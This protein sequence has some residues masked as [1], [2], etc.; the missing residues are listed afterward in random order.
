MDSCVLKTLNA[1]SWCWSWISLSIRVLMQYVFIAKCSLLAYSMKVSTAFLAMTSSVNW[2]WALESRSL[3]Y[4]DMVRGSLLSI[5]RYSSKEM[6]PL[7]YGWNVSYAVTSYPK[8]TCV[9]S[10]AAF[11]MKRT[12]NCC[13]YLL[14]VSKIIRAMED[15]AIS[16]PTDARNERAT[17]IAWII[18]I[19]MSWMEIAL[20]DWENQSSIWVLRSSLKR[21]SLQVRDT[22]ATVIAI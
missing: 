22:R 9:L 10:R 16:S 18:A 20:I 14:N 2:Y 17:S 7:L 3:T 21:I 19:L 12:M 11:M 15:I 13:R 4:R 1:I 5:P 8:P 6:S